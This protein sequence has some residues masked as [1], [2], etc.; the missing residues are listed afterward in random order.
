MQVAVFNEFTRKVR[1]EISVADSA[2]VIKAPTKLC[3]LGE[4]ER[5]VSNPETKNMAILQVEN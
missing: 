2:D 3:L 5:S 4:C 1:V